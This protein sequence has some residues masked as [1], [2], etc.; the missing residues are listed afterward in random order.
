MPRT[1]SQTSPFKVLR[2]KPRRCSDQV[3]VGSACNS[4]ATMA[5]IL[6]SNPS[7]RS[8]ENG[9][10]FGSTQTRNSRACAAPTLSRTHPTKTLRKAEHIECASLHR[11]VFQIAHGVDE[12]KRGGSVARIEIAG[13]DCARPAAYAGEDRDI[14]LALG[15]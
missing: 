14:L 8:L 12:T 1:R 3:Y 5:T 15:P 11:R 4:C 2:M 9:K 7:S 13:H 10:L 6:F